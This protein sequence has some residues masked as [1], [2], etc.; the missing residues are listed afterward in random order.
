M[1]FQTGL[2]GLNAASRNLEVIGHNIANANTTG[3]KASRAEFSE[4]YASSLGATG[5]TNVGIGVQVATVAQMF[6]QG[7]LKMTGNQL[8]LAI[9]G[10]GFFPV[11]G[12]DGTPMFTRN[13][14]FKLDQGGF[15]ITNNGARLQQFAIN[16]AGLPGT[17]LSDL[18]LPTGGINPRAT[19]VTPANPNSRGIEL[20]ANLDARAPILPPPGAPLTAEQRRFGTA[21]TAFDAQGSDLPIQIYFIKTGANTWEVRASQ[22]NGTTLLPG[23][24]P[25]TFDGNGQLNL[26]LTGWTNITIP[27]AT[28]PAIVP[29]AAMNIP[30]TLTSPPT[31]AHPNGT[32]TVTQFGANFSLFD[33]KQD[34]YATGNLTSIDI[35]EDGLIMSRFSN[36]ISRAEGQ[37]ALANFRNLQGLQPL[38]GGFWAETFRSGQPNMGTPQ[39]AGLGLVRQNALEESNVEL[40]QELVNMMVAQRSYQAN[41]QTIRTQDQVLQTLVNM[42]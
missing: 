30:I 8:D 9:N 12:T 15:V 20:S 32:P 28:P 33:L 16:A 23:G 29:S 25:L 37:L 5:G 21:L 1:S 6:T 17:E 22:D 38:N 19:G 14:E 2:S 35:G 13:G 42:R 3:M 26:P 34:G 40:T 7:N 27:A 10:T 36:G 39:N 24:G 4:L 31:L 11:K 41:A 18:R